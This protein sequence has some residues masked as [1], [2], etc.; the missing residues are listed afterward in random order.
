MESLGAAARR[1]LAGLDARRAKEID[2]GTVSGCRLT[3]TEPLNAGESVSPKD[4]ADAP[5]ASGMRLPLA[6]GREADRVPRPFASRPSG[7]QVA[8][9]NCNRRHADTLS[10]STAGTRLARAISESSSAD[11][12]ATVTPRASA[13]GRSAS[14]T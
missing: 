4:R 3:P 5:R 1:L 7:A 6:L 12:S 10:S 2:R 8:A 11:S 9:A 14:A 13:S